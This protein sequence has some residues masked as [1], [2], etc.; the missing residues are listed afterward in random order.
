MGT[1]KY[2]EKYPKCGSTRSCHSYPI[3]LTLL[4]RIQELQVFRVQN[5]DGRCLGG[6]EGEGRGGGG[7]EGGRGGG[8][9]G[10]R[11]GGGKGGG[12][13]GVSF[14]FSV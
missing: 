8:G 10:G 11:E 7:G 13:E 3:L 5:P 2:G 6:G 12:G 1:K 4:I 14:G 9:E